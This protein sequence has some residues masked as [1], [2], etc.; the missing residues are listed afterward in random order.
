MDQEYYALSKDY[1]ELYDLAMKGNKIFCYSN[2]HGMTWKQGQPV[3]RD[4]CI[5]R[6][7]EVRKGLGFWARGISY[8]DADKF[9]ADYERVTEK[10]CFINLCKSQNI[11]W[12]RKI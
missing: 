1:E 4:P 10:E 3:H 8:G 5:C 7:S 6:Y 9:T 12:V 2:Y 11:E